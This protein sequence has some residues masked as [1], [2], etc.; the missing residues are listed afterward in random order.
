MFYHRLKVVSQNDSA[1]FPLRAHV[2]HAMYN[3]HWIPLLSGISDFSF[4]SQTLS[5]SGIDPNSQ[6]NDFPHKM[7]KIMMQ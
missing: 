1:L 7:K 5:V 3:S 6:E 4:R 2:Y